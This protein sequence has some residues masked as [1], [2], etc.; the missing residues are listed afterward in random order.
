MYKHFINSN[1]NPLKNDI[2][3]WILSDPIWL[4]FNKVFFLVQKDIK[5]FTKIIPNINLI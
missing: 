1:R 4:I 5:K 3:I 2:K